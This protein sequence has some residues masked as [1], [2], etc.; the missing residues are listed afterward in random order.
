MDPL[1]GIPL[2]GDLPPLEGRR[3]LVRVDFNVPLHI[4]ID[5][6]AHHTAA[7][8]RARTAMLRA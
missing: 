1:R 6:M 3:V 7:V 2:L 4:D 8:A 5:V